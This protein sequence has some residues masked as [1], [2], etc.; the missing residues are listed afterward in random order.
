MF[1]LTFFNV[2]R[3]VLDWTEAPVNH[4]I[5]EHQRYVEKSTNVPLFARRMQEF[6]MMSRDVRML[7]VYVSVTYP[8][9]FGVVLR[10]SGA[11]V[12]EYQTVY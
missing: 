2:V 9:Y 10:S 1:D 4:Y 11:A 7:H 3:K 8:S 6:D 5:N 12:Q